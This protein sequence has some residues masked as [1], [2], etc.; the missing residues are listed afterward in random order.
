MNSEYRAG[1]ADGMH[2]VFGVVRD[3]IA[4]VL[5]IPPGSVTPGTRLRD[6]LGA[7]SLDL[8]EIVTRIEAR[9]GAVIEPSRLPSIATVA[10]ACAVLA[11]DV[12]FAA[13]AARA[14]D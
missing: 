7:D 9:S 14:G 12:V 4:E 6:D 10:D 3:C 8:A 13:D 5:D 11:A 2:S 1:A